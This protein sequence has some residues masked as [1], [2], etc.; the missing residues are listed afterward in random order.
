M[1][2]IFGYGT[3]LLCLLGMLSAFGPFVTDMYLPALPQLQSFFSTDASM[4]QL[5]LSTSMIGLAI[6]QIFIGPL[7]DKYGRKPLLLVSMWIFIASTIL[8][9]FAQSIQMFVALRCLQ[10]V[11]GAGGIVLSRSIATDRYWGEKLAKMM[12][13][14]GAINGIA[15]VTAPI[16]GG[17]MTDSLGWQGIF[18]ALLIVGI[19]LI[20]GSY[21]MKETLMPEKRSEESV[22]R[23]FTSF[24]KILTNPRFTNIWLQYGFCGAA[25][26]TYI[27]SSPFIIQQHYGFSPFM[28]SIIFGFNALL[29]GIGCGTS[30]KFKTPVHCTYY[31]SIVLFVAAVAECA[32]MLSN[33]PF[34]L[35]E[36]L[37][38]IILSGIGLCFTSSTVA[39]LNEEHDNAGAASALVGAILFAAGGIVSPI[40][41]LG[42]LEHTTGISFVV[43]SAICLFFAVRS[44]KVLQ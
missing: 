28:F 14:I 4:A 16:V 17:L 20:I 15:P 7:S 24:K 6:G 18:I 39:A 5:S 27:A 22:L 41:G 9:I 42:T 10:G 29:I 38:A 43:C 31:A 37:V 11:G 33:G 34:W 26:F 32:V 36:V 13:V 12:A 35:Y 44:K 8:C 2:K 30:A 23:T 1:K 21:I 3:F 19:I 25:F 40:V